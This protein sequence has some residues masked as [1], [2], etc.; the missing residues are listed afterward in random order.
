MKT[1]I[2][3]LASCLFFTNIALAQSIELP[4]LRGKWLNKNGAGIEI[5]GSAQMYI[6]YAG[7][8]REIVSYEADF[9]K[10]P[11]WFDFTVKHEGKVVKLKSLIYLLENDLLKWQIFE[12]DTRPAYFTLDKGETLYLKK[13]KMLIN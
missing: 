11:A 13:V 10:T 8:K 6:V 9:S 7:E 1:I 5:A 3:F 2:Y 12:S 4:T